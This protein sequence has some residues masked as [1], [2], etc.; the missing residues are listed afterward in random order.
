M[1]LMAAPASVALPKIQA[2]AQEQSSS[3]LQSRADTHK[4][5]I[6]GLARALQTQGQIA[7]ERS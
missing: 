7:V 2:A 5:L 1:M 3:L 6:N 4:S